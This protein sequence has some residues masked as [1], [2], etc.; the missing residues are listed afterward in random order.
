MPVNDKIRKPDYN[1]IRAK[2][3]NVIE[4]GSGTSGWG[5]IMV[6]STDVDESKKVSVN[7]WGRMRYDIINAYK[8]IYGTTPTAVSPAEGNTVRYS[9]TFGPNTTTDAPVTQFDTYANTIIA[10]R[11]TVHSSQSATYSWPTASTTW[12]GPY[13]SIW[14]T[15][16][17][18]VVTVSWPTAAAARHF[19]NSGGLIRF[20]SSRSGGSAIGQNTSWTSILSAA[21][22]QSFGGNTPSAGVSPQDGGNYYRCTSTYQ[23][24]YSTSGSSPYGANVYRISARTPGI[25]NNTTGTAATVEFLVEWIDNYVDPGPEPSPPP[26][27]QVD[28]TMSLSVSHLYA[29][30]VL[31]PPGT[32][33][34]TVTQPSISIGT[35]GP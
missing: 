25:A 28:G 9:N 4:T 30:G 20:S 34:F 15:K 5:Q 18:C 12:P 1:D 24:W 32:G 8:H 2:L 26:G 6:A 35:I 14:N 16:I 23:T 33:N 31:E 19:F 27:D 10:N 13:G 21:G 22:M 17:Q 3:A 7:E 11:F 29:T